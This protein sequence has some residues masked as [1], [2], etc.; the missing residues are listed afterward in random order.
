MLSLPK[1][2]S[3]SAVGD[4]RPIA[5]TSVLTKI[6]EKIMSRKLSHFLEGN[7]MLPLQFSYR[8]GLGTCDALLTLFYHCRLLDKARRLVLLDFS[9]AFDNGSH[10]GLLQKLRFI[11][12][13]GP[14]ENHNFNNMR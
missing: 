11:G 6:F 13:G 8:N 7:S 14:Q 10:R 3:S 4:F 12:V 5:I 1:E 9:A 2:S